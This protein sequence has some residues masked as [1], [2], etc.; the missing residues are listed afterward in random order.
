M[1][2]VEWRFCGVSCSECIVVKYKPVDQI[3]LVKRF[4]CID[5]DFI[6]NV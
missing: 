4:E 2:T 1:S 5:L 3:R 6:F